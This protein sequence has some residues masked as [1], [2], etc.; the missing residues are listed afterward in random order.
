MSLLKK[1]EEARAELGARVRDPWNAR[2]EHALHGIEMISSAATTNVSES[3]SSATFVSQTQPTRMIAPYTICWTAGV[4]P[5]PMRTVRS[6]VRN[7]APME[8]RV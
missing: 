1:L 6:T 8:V 7:S 5:C 2:L 4:A 3:I